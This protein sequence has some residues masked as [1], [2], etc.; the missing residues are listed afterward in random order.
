M[1]CPWTIE[2]WEG[3]EM[4]GFDVID[5]EGDYFPKAGEVVGP[6]GWCF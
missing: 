6:L 5:A 2:F 3:D 4:E 1:K